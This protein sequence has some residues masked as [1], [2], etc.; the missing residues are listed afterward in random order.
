MME[1]G[2][3]G[4]SLQSLALPPWAQHKSQVLG[5]SRSGFWSLS[6]AQLPPAPPG[7][8]GWQVRRCDLRLGPVVTPRAASLSCCPS[9]PLSGGRSI[10]A[11]SCSGMTCSVHGQGRVWGDPQQDRPRSPRETGQDRP[12]H[13]PA[14]PGAGAAPTP[15]ARDAP[16]IPGLPNQL[17]VM[18]APAPAA[19][20]RLQHL[21][22]VKP[23]R[24][25]MKR[26][27]ER[28][29]GAGEE[30]SCPGTCDSSVFLFPCRQTQQL[31]H[32]DAAAAEGW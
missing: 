19:P 8:E 24:E 15:R 7:T 23:A 12:R 16:S 5:V 27:P 10:P 3:A 6:G 2:G 28:G 29:L 30:G 17:L 32:A 13:I 9:L 26:H 25:G 1:R 21:L 11:A 31:L 22:G 18:P 20:S 14:L 4:L